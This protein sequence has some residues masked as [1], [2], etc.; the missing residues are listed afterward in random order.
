MNRIRNKYK[1]GI[2]LTL[3]IGLAVLLLIQGGKKQKE[4]VSWKEGGERFAAFFEALPEKEANTWKEKAKAQEEKMPCEALMELAELFTSKNLVEAGV[5][6]ELEQKLSLWK[7]KGEYVREEALKEA[8]ILLAEYSLIPESI[9]RFDV[10]CFGEKG[11]L[12]EQRAIE[13]SEGILSAKE[14]FELLKCGYSYSVILEGSC[15]TEVLGYARER[16]VLKN[17]W[18]TEAEETK[19]TVFYQGVTSTLYLEQPL[20]VRLTGVVAD[21]TLASE[22]VVGLAVKNNLITAKVLRADK[23]G[24]ELE[25][26]GKLS[27]EEDYKIYKIYGE[28][29]EERTS[30]ILVGYTVTSFAISGSKISA[31][32]ITEPIQV[33][34]IRVLIQNSSYG[35]YYH[36]ELTVTSE[37]RFYLSDGS[38]NTV[39]YEAGETV[40]VTKEMVEKAS[41][42]VYLGT[43][44]ESGKL[45]FPDMKRAVGA[46]SYR[47]TMEIA[48]LSGGMILINEL[49]IEE[50]LYGVVPSEMPASFGMEALK[51]QAVCARSYACNQLLANRFYQYGAHVDDSTVS[52]VYMNYGENEDAVFAVKDTFG[53]ILTYED[54]CITAYYFS[55]S[56]GH[57]SDSRDVWGEEMTEGYLYGGCQSKEGGRLKLQSEEAFEEFFFSDREWY[58]EEAVWFRWDTTLPNGMEELLYQRLCGRYEKVPELILKQKTDADGTKRYVSEKIESLGTLENIVIAARGNSG[59]VTELLLVGSEN[60]YLIKREYNIRAILASPAA[61]TLADGST[62]SNMALLPSAYIQ[63]SRQEDGFLIEGGGYGHGVGM[64]QYGAKAMASQG[65]SYEEIL[66]HF[67]PG[68]ELTFLYRP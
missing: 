59:I 28:L 13:T 30:S 36:E 60:T 58:D 44:K 3:L 37:C 18:I 25:G 68:T 15:I 16:V 43:E 53:K 55:C 8:Y 67:Y 51:A 38:E 21:V 47:G 34:N 9:G 66:K 20:A 11:A 1:L 35:G 4:G 52:Q 65:E 41:G 6:T 7:K 62:T 22:Y 46:P 29:A 49:S 23:N 14:S 17:A 26:Y 45:T 27:F 64:S 56:Y 48:L 61:I 32:L 12:P 54:K 2:S 57:T 24:V 10:F 5:L 33:T 42:R 63:I 39:W 31:A 40:R 19:L 50:Y